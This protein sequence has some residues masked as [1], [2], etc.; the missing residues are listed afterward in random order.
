MT[1]AIFIVLLIALMLSVS[2]CGIFKAIGRVVCPET[3]Q[4]PSEQKPQDKVVNYTWWM[5]PL[6]LFGI[7]VAIFLVLG[8]KQLKLG[9][10]LAAAIL[11]ASSE[12]CERTS[13]RCPWVK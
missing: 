5:I 12:A 2:G 1:R 3:I 7:G 10:A 4:P 11:P 8:L 9:I 13:T 6:C